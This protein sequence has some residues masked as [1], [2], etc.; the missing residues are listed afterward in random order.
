MLGDSELRFR[1]RQQLFRRLADRGFEGSADGDGS[2]STIFT[3]EY[4]ID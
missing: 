2:S 1:R 4:R 3:A